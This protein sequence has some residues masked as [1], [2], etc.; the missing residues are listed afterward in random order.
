MYTVER[1]DL[2]LRTPPP[3]LDKLSIPK[4]PLALDRIA[5]LH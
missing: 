3:G 4:V 5:F 1:Q 2:V